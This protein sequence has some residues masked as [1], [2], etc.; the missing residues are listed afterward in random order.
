[1]TTQKHSKTTPAGSA[2][3]PLAY[4][5]V[6]VH[7][8]LLPSITNFPYHPQDSSSSSGAPSFRPFRRL[9]IQEVTHL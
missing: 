4:K 3:S 9:L 8:G 7:G 6:V 2:A 5:Y 1:M